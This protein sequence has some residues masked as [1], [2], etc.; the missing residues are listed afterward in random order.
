MR[1]ARTRVRRGKDK[2]IFRRTAN[3]TRA[4]NIGS[5]PMRGGIRL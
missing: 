2:A 1:I 3:S 4:A 5:S